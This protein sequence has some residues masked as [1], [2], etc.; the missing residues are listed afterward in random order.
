M[1]GGTLPAAHLQT[2]M[3]AQHPR[4]DIQGSTSKGR[5]PSPDRRQGCRKKN[6]AR[7]KAGKNLSGRTAKNARPKNCGHFQISGQNHGGK[8][9]A[10]TYWH[11]KTGLFK[12]AWRDSNPRPLAPQEPLK[13]PLIA[14]FPRENLTLPHLSAHRKID[15]FSRCFSRFSSANVSTDT[16]PG[17]LRVISQ[18]LLRND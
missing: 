16:Y 10:D 7:I 11:F 2:R 6:S 15:T 17:K 9:S 5:H 12:S 18:T 3:D 14:R 13:T 8:K 1:Q 4:V